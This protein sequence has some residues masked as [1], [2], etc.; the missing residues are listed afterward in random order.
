MTPEEL[1]DN[2]VRWGE[3]GIPRAGC[4]RDEAGRAGSLPAD[5]RTPR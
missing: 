5:K 3:A 2:I 1:K 4:R